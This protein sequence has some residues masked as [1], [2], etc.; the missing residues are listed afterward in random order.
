MDILIYSLSH[1]PTKMLREEICWK[2]KS[3]T[4]YRTPFLAQ[5]ALLYCDTET[6]ASAYLN[7][8]PIWAHSDLLLKKLKLKFLPRRGYEGPDME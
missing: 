5:N 1:P 4:S 6:G 7:G 3:Y 2:R 8:F